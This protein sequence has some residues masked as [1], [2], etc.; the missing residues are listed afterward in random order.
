ME[1]KSMRR[2]KLIYHCSEST[3]FNH[4]IRFEDSDDQSAGA[5]V[6]NDIR[7]AGAEIIS[8]LNSEVLTGLFNFNLVRQANMQMDYSNIRAVEISESYYELEK[9]TARLIRCMQDTPDKR[10]QM[11]DVMECLKKEMGETCI[12]QEQL[13]IERSEGG[14]YR[15]SE[16]YRIEDGSFTFR[17]Y[18]MAVAAL[19]YEY[20]ENPVNTLHE[21]FSSF[22]MQQT[23]PYATMK[24]DA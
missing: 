9:L 21:A 13:V 12:R 11:T 2:I 15:E 10:R 5:V 17:L 16:S 18:A 1:E 23:A 20:S 3:G 14:R 22:W 24:Q 19:L 6:A 8:Q 4:I 7:Q